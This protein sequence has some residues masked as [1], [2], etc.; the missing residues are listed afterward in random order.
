MLK[1]SLNV[2]LFKNIKVDPWITP[3][4]SS[5]SSIIIIIQQDFV[6]QIFSQIEMI[7]I[8]KIKKFPQK[9]KLV[10]QTHIISNSHNWCT[11]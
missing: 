10:F 7:W 8:M 4:F 1:N 11:K 9:G 5:N 3:L 6:L 2:A